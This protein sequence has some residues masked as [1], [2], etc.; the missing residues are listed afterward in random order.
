MKTT[1]QILLFLLL[2]VGSQNIDAQSNYK[3]WYIITNEQDTFCRWI[4]F[5][6][7]VYEI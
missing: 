5:R 6:V 7:P 2:L 1:K 3:Q 4:D